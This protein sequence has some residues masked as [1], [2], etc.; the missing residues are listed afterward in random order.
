MQKT[1]VD[2]T[3]SYKHSPVVRTTRECGMWNLEV[4][5]NAAYLFVL[6]MITLHLCNIL[7]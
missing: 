6:Q 3:Y 5:I 7:W 1:I 2:A 4:R